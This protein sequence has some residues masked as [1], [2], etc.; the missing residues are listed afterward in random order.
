MNR[1]LVAGLAAAT[2]LAGGCGGGSGE[3]GPGQAGP[4]PRTS[5]AVI[6]PD[7]RLGPTQGSG[8]VPEAEA[9]V[10]VDCQA[11]LGKGDFESAAEQ[12]GRVASSGD[13]TPGERAIARVCQA[14]ANANAG[15][16]HKALDIVDQTD[17]RS[18]SPGL[19][20]KF[21]ELLY[22]TELVSAAAVGDDERVQKALAQLTELGLK[23]ADYVRD[24]CAA[25]SDPAALP[26][27]ATVAPPA[28]ATGSP[29]GEPETPVTSHPEESGTTP[30][31]ETT[32]ESPGE[33]PPATGDGGPTPDES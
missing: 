27:C 28:T 25:A 31:E 30:T 12:M 7:S 24:A 18:I 1:A 13:S 29:P 16:P 9:Q 21:Q 10:G 5:R 20:L 2:V 6:T 17:T 14:A 33:G 4:G 15:R 23:P 3:S 26:Q 11:T 19:R 22:H 32:T 8:D